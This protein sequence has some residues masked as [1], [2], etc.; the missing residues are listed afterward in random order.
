MKTCEYRRNRTNRIN[1]SNNCGHHYRGQ[2][3]RAL[4]SSKSCFRGIN[5]VGRFIRETKEEA[6]IME[7]AGQ[8][9]GIFFCI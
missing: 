4:V 3:S 7:A 1:K 5:Q 9:A 6:A 2:S 8:S